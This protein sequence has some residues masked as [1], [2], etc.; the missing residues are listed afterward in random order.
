MWFLCG[1]FAVILIV[2]DHVGVVD[3]PVVEDAEDVLSGPV[4]V[5]AQQEI[6]EAEE[7]VLSVKGHKTPQEY[8]A[9][10]NSVNLKI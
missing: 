6:G 3:F 5:A 7:V 8:W 2:L 9:H 1:L 4:N 10:C